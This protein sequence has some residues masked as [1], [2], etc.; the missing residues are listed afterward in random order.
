MHSQKA[1]CSSF[2]SQDICPARLLHTTSCGDIANEPDD[3]TGQTTDG[4][5]CQDQPVAP[6][7]SLVGI[8]QRHRR[9]GPELKSSSTNLVYGCASHIVS[10]CSSCNAFLSACVHLAEPSFR[11]SHFWVLE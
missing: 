11:V 8:A 6:I 3:R 10:C 4:H 2:S 5:F 9:G 1:V 7:T